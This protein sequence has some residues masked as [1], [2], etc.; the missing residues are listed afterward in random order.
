MKMDADVSAA[1]EKF[2][3]LCKRPPTR[4]N[5]SETL[6][7]FNTYVVLLLSRDQASNTGE[8]K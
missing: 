4:R 7:A 8:Q 2:E 6:A 5:L 3:A 1:K